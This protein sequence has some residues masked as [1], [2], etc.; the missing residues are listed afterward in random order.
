MMLLRSLLAL[1]AL[2]AACR[3][4]VAEDAAKLPPKEKFHLFLLVGQSN[5][6]GRGKVEPSDQTPNPR[7][8][9]FNKEGAWVP[10]VDPMH[11]DKPTA[12]V[13]LGRTFGLL[14]AEADPTITVGL[15][16]CAHGGSPIESWQPG[17]FFAQT[18]GHPWDDTML[19]A[20]AAL[21]HGTLKGILWHQGESDANDNA[22][23][24][25][26][27]KL[28]DLVTRF[29]KELSADDVPFIVGQL[30]KFADAPW[31]IQ[32]EQI[33]AAH[34]GLPERVKNTAY[35]SAEG[36]QH[37]GDKG[38]FDS[39]GYRELGRRY[40]AAYQKLTAAQPAASSNSATEA[41]PAAPAK[42][43][44]KITPGQV[45]VPTDAMRRPWGELVSVDLEKRTGMFRSESTDEIMPFTVMPYAELL[46]HAAF[47]DLDDY[48]VGE[49]AIFRLHENDAGQWTWLTYIQDEMNF[50]NGH[51]EYYHVDAIDPVKRTFTF[52]QANLDKSFVRQQGLVL[53]TDAETRFWKNGEPAKF[54]DVQV[55]T[56]LRTKTHGAGKGA[57]R[58]CWEV[59]LDEP[60]LLKFQ[61]EQK[62]AH[63]KKLAEFGGPGYVDRSADGEVDVTLFQETGEIARG[64]KPK[65]IVQIAPAGDDRR[66]KQGPV[67]AVVVSAR[68]QGN[69]GKATLRIESDSV[70]P[71]FRVGGLCRIWAAK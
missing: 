67:P 17:K 31:A 36:L 70:E 71:E 28:D 26:Q 9:M 2:F 14:A 11:F 62:A 35:V 69:L 39:P 19:R 40:F 47:G 49:R 25:Y 33:D 24:T 7:V 63:A 20:K 1:V 61:A 18:K 41:K 64:L 46:H 65:Q 10:A 56:P 13:G 60:S 27:A 30:G 66:A 12:G 48:R 22:A 53:E 34:R 68:M 23:P 58:I 37:K 43:K 3:T 5:M 29:R 6:A 42:P 16:P 38:H 51:K 8:L 44:L 59:F 32:K 45:I 57:R 15:I 50:L 52:T 55:G 4:S 21:E 54:E